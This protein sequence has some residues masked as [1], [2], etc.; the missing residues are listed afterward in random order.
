MRHQ[1]IENSIRSSTVDARP[2]PCLQG[3]GLRRLPPPLRA[4]T[5]VLVRIATPRNRSPTPVSGLSGIFQ[6]GH[7]EPPPLA[8]LSGRVAR[9]YRPYTRRAGLFCAGDTSPLRSSSFP[10]S[11]L[12]RRFG[13]GNATPRSPSKPPH[14]PETLPPRP[15]SEGP[16]REAW[17]KPFR[18]LEPSV[19]PR[20][21]GPRRHH[22]D[23]PRLESRA[24]RRWAMPRGLFF[25]ATFPEPWQ[26]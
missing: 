13:V 9:R 3:P 26:L 5:E 10:P 11:Q 2:L 4:N 6:A 1:L 25:F 19:R 17:S 16:A 7:A 18:S 24:S 14:D 22:R 15:C 21:I 23:A 8:A 20:L 12:G